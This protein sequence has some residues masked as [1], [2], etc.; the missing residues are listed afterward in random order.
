M[1]IGTVSSSC[2]RV[3][4]AGHSGALVLDAWVW[5]VFGSCFFPVEK[6]PFRVDPMDG[7][8]VPVG[9]AL[10]LPEVCPRVFLAPGAMYICDFG[11]H[12]QFEV[13]HFVRGAAYSASEYS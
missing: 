1:G 13:S 2:V 10:A 4:F 3:R 12:P 8:V 6:V 11:G 5:C 9:V 7:A